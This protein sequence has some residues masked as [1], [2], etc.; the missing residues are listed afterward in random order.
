ME[1]E[2]GITETLSRAEY[3]QIIGEEIKHGVL[4]KRSVGNIIPD[5]GHR[6]GDW[7]KDLGRIMDTVMNNIFQRGRAVQVAGTES[8][9]GSFSV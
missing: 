2:S 9:T 6:T 8:R 4:N 5:I 1:T 3:E 7:V